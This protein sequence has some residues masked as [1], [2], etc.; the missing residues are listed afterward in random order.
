MT[1]K[2]TKHTSGDGQHHDIPP[3]WVDVRAAQTDRLRIEVQL[4]GRF[5]GGILEW[6]VP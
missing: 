6:Q 5:S 2:L 4:R 1:S 3:N